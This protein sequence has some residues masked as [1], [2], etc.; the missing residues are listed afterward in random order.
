VKVGGLRIASATTDLLLVNLQRVA[1]CHVKRIWVVCWIH[2]RAIKEEAHA[3][4]SLA[5][6]LAESIHKL[7]QLCCTLDLEEDLVIAVGDLDVEVL[8]FTAL[9]AWCA[10]W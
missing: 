6:S 1:V 9:W 4:G 2:S 3:G 8:A 5:T 10:V 7:L